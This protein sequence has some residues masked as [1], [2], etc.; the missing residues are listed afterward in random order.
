MTDVD[1]TFTREGRLLHIEGVNLSLGEG[2]ERRLIL[3]DVNADVA[4]IVRPGKQ[5]GQVIGFLGPSGIGK[6]QLFRTI[7][8]FQQPD[9]G[10]VL[11]GKDQNPTE[12]GMVGVVTQHYRVFNHRTVLDNLVFAGI[13]G[14]L[15]KAEATDKA[16]EYLSQFDLS[17]QRNHWP[18][19]L[20][21]GQRQRLAILQQIMVGHDTICMDEPFSGLD[22]NQVQKVARLISALTSKDEFLT[23]IVVTHDIGAALEVSD[24][25]WLMGQERD[26]EKP[27]EFLPGARIVA[28]SDLIAEGLAWDP[29]IRHNPKYIELEKLVANKFRELTHVA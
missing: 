17:D 10:K 14:S 28:Q 12:P 22:I 27:A 21:G 4:N 8:G 3:R 11:V 15:S 19:R 29:D 1:R 26:P 9:S 5:Q 7:A 13:Q 25:L 2:S 23:I 6:T 24:T 18:A 16:N 20:S